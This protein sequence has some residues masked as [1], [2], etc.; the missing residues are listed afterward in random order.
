MQTR[1]ENETPRTDDSAEEKPRIVVNDRRHWARQ[2]DGEEEQDT[3]PNKPTYVAELESKLEAQEKLVAEIRA[4]AKSAKSEFENARARLQRD[5][6]V[7]VKRGVRQ[8]LTS[9]LEVMD[10]LDRALEAAHDPKADQESLRDG[11]KMVREQFL[12]ALGEVGVQRVETVGQ[13]FDP[14]R[15][16]AVSNV[17]VSDPSQDQRVVGEIKGLYLMGDDVLRP[18]VV[19]VGQHR[20]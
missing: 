7:E 14:E 5:V 3:R 12:H 10:N 8:I 16:E 6:Q 20:G 15:H 18:G 13:P 11:M 9:L 4:Q 2:D 1:P 17:P 19:A